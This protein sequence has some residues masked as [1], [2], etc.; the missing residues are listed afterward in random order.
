MV[1]T[2]ELLAA[3]DAFY[4]ALSGLDLASMESAWHHDDWVRCVHPGWDVLVGWRAVRASFERIFRD[5]GWIRVI[6]TAV[7][8]RALGDLGIVACT[9]NITSSDNGEVGV[10]VAQATNVFR[11]TEDGWRMIVHHSS[12]A[13]VTV[14]SAFSGTVQ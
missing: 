6:P 2:D 4:S 1:E 14:T 3:N 7:T 10:G 12:P 13:P 11:R 9:E 5:T 8:G